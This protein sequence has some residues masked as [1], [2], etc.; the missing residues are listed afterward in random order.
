MHYFFCLTRCTG[1]NIHQG[2]LQAK[3]TTEV[4][5]SLGNVKCNEVGGAMYE[6][7]RITLPKQAIEAAKVSVLFPAS[8]SGAALQNTV[9]NGYPRCT[10][11]RISGTREFFS[12]RL[13]RN[14]FRGMKFDIQTWLFIRW[15]TLSTIQWI[16]MGETNCT[17]QWIEIYPVDRVIQLLNSWGLLYLW[18]PESR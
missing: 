12:C 17:I 6:F 10:V 2:F 14:Q 18:S 1:S 9:S 4:L 3:M 13:I 7:P 15:I 11:I 8:I 16:G 5:N